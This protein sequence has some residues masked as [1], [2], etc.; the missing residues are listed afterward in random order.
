MY[1]IN[2][3]IIFGKC[4]KYFFYVT[5]A[6]NI[7]P[8]VYLGLILTIFNEGVYL[9]FTSQSSIWPAIYFSSIVKSR[10][11]PFLEPTST[12]Q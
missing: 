8:F 11:N 7:V 10:S 6:N 2:V 5:I 12:K 1:S 3:G 4:L 9:T